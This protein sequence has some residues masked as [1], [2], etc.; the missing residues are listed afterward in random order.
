MALE[1]S[2]VIVL[3]SLL[4][5]ATLANLLAELYSSKEEVQHLISTPACLYLFESSLLFAPLLVLYKCFRF[6]LQ[7]QCHFS[8]ISH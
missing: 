8:A 2:V 7:L 3:D 1:F 4:A 6:A 5:C